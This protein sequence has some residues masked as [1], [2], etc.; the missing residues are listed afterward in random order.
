MPIQTGKEHSMHTISHAAN[1]FALLLNPADVIAQ[2]ECSE[3]LRRLQSRICRP[4]DKPVIPCATEDG[5]DA[6][7]AAPDADISDII[8]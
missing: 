4:L 7:L 1:P 5:F 6:E 8:R 3:R 2:V